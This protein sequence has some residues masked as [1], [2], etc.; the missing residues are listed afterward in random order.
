MQIDQNVELSGPLA[1][2]GRT[3]VIKDVNTQMTRQ[4]A[5]CLASKITAATGEAPVP[6]AANDLAQPTDVRVLPLLLRSLWSRLK[7]KLGRRD[8]D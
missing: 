8:A 4:F 2:F 5:Q 3:A 6:G 7:Q 1:Q